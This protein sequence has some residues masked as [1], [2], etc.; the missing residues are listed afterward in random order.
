MDVLI[1]STRGFEQDIARLSE[2]DKATAI[3]K[4]NDCASLFPI[5]KADVYRKLRRIPLTSDLNGYE[6]SLYTLRVSQKLRVI[7]AVDEDPI[8]GQVIFTLFRAVKHDDID[9]AYKGIAESLYQELLQD[10]RETV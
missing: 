8:F 10:N 3:Q 2:D 9:K 5:Q 6:S 7:L 1:E 4:I